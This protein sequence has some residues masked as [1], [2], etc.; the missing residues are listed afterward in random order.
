[1]SPAPNAATSGGNKTRMTVRTKKVVTIAGGMTYKRLFACRLSM[2]AGRVLV[3]EEKRPGDDRPSFKLPSAKP[4]PSPDEVAMMSSCS[5]RKRSH[6]T[7]ARE[8]CNWPCSCVRRRGEHFSAHFLGAFRLQALHPVFE[9]Q[10]SHSERN[11][12]TKVRA[13]GYLRGACFDIRG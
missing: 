10:T 1:M 4:F 11:P 2:G 6:A 13:S 9:R 12:P 3:Q 7:A 8:A 5:G